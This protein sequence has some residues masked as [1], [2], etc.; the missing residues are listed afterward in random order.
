[1]DKFGKRFSSLVS[2]LV[3]LFKTSESSI[4]ILLKGPGLLIDKL[5]VRREIPE[6]GRK[7]LS[8]LLDGGSGVAAVTG[9]LLALI[10]QNHIVIPAF[11][12]DIQR[13]SKYE[14]VPETGARIY[15][16]AKIKVVT[17]IPCKILQ[18]KVSCEELRFIVF[19]KWHCKLHMRQMNLI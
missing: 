15:A 16:D 10:L 7:C 11:S 6:Y 5:A 18:N 12:H 3:E 9:G 17:F 4:L 1:M 19:D 8:V 13:V 14:M 2:T